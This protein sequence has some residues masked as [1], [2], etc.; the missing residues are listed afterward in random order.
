V[1]AK[2]SRLL[3]VTGLALV[4]T[5]SAG[6]SEFVRD[7]RAPARLVIELL[8]GASGAEP[9]EMGGS[10][11]SDVITMV[12]SP[13]PC[14]EENPCPTRF[15]D[16]GRVTLRLQLRDIGDSA[17]PNA[18]SQLNAVTITRY[19]VRYHRTDNRN[20][21]GVDVPYGF[22]SSVTF[23][24]PSGGN[25]TASFELV[26]L[27]AKREAPLAALVDGQTIISGI[28]DITFY[29]HDQSGNE[30]SVTGS[31]GVSFGNFADPA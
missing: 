29:G 5:L 17:S 2:F 25:A 1:T 23:T 14:S 15:N 6:C 24:V 16:L 3:T 21:P 30:V 28:A 9:N 13:A 4:S 31:I 19:S 26:R 8:E 7:G 27:I 18:P 11:Q 22:D 12:T 10:L 20:T